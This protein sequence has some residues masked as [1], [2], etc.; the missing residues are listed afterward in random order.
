MSQL[1]SENRPSQEQLLGRAVYS[2]VLQIV[3]CLPAYHILRTDGQNVVTDKFALPE[4]P[5]VTN[6]HFATKAE[7]GSFEID[8]ELRRI[9]QNVIVSNVLNKVE[10]TKAYLLGRKI[11]LNSNGE[12]TS[13][14]NKFGTLNDEEERAFRQYLE[15]NRLSLED[16]RVDRSPLRGRSGMEIDY[17]IHL[18]THFC[19][20]YP[21]FRPA[22][23]ISTWILL[24][25]A[26]Y[27]EPQE[28]I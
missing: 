6:I 12:I 8:I 15:E 26:D 18:L 11:D 22:L 21:E 20:N 25:K 17:L 28:L 2:Y 23:P 16:L 10:P 7:L 5:L 19:T 1:D 3:T 4:E 9:P 27:D 13:R 24:F 14:N